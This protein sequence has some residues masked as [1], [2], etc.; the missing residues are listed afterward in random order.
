[1]DTSDNPQS[2]QNNIPDSKCVLDMPNEEGNVISN[3]PR[4]SGASIVSTAALIISSILFIAGI[5]VCASGSLDAVATGGI[6]I[7]LSMATLVAGLIIAAISAAK[8]KK[9]TH[10]ESAEEG[11]AKKTNTVFYILIVIVS[12]ILSGILWMFLQF[13][14]FVNMIH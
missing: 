13:F 3:N 9:R 11:A 6:L 4:M 2:E 7:L 1:M 12:L 8:E 14:V 10:D 5:T